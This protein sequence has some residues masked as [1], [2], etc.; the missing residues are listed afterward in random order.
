MTKHA[1]KNYYQTDSYKKRLKKRYFFES[2][3]RK[4]GCFAILLSTIFLLTLLSSIVEKGYRAFWQNEIK[5][6][7]AGIDTPLR[8]QILSSDNTAQMTAVKNILTMALNTTQKYEFHTTNLTDSEIY[9]MISPTTIYILKKKFSKNPK[10]LNKP[11]EI[12]IP[13]SDKV[14][15]FLKNTRSES[16][17]ANTELIRKI[18]EN[19]L[20]WLQ[21]QFNKKNISEK[22]NFGFFADG[23]SRYPESAG[24]LSGLVG[25]ALTIF[26]T[27]LL[28]LIFGISSAI[29]LEEFAKK[30]WFTDFLEVNINNL[31]AVPSIIFGLLGLTIFI[32]FFHIPR[33]TPLIGGIVLSLMTLPTIIITT[34]VTMRAIPISI[35]H[36][37][38]GM[39]ASPV[40]TIFHHI[41]PLAIPGILTGAIISI[42]R[43]LGETAPLLLIGMVAFV[44]DTP[45]S[46][47]DSATTLPVQIYMWASSPEPAFIEKAS[48]AIMILLALLIILNSAAAYIR[49]KYER[50][51]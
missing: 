38:L 8:A 7:I 43:A 9:S 46:I 45:F 29:Y 33:S 47:F 18:N 16:L 32:H 2:L 4:A 36:A 6:T 17:S 22:F 48:G 10:L 28:S 41:L 25:S 23:S 5:L 49:K 20:I 40:Q 30:N 26:I 27:V 44:V 50:R 3:F 51:W 21:S 12:W 31:A 11:F 13:L 14:D 39:G 35:R 24:I 34:R 37:A 1:Q 19:Q 15:Q 42:A